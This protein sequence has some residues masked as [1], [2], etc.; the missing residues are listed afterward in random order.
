MKL[1]KFMYALMAGM[2]L[3]ACSPGGDGPEPSPTP[4]PSPSPS[5]GDKVDISNQVNGRW[6][7]TKVDDKEVATNNREVI[8]FLTGGIGTLSSWY[9]GQLQVNYSLDGYGLYF[10]TTLANGDFMEYF[11]EVTYVTESEM[12]QRHY[13]YG[14]NK[15]YKD[16]S[17]YRVYQKST[18][19]IGNKIIG[20]W[21]DT[22][23]NAKYRWEFLAN[24]TYNQYQKN[25]KGKWQ[26][27]D[28]KNN[29]YFV[30]SNWLAIGEENCWDIVQVTDTHMIWSALRVDS[31]G[32]TYEEAISLDKTEPE[33]D[34][35]DTTGGIDDMPIEN[36]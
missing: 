19:T 34:E 15:N 24:G 21:E 8:S 2:V 27:V 26:K 30:D 14:E 13:R 9:A 10:S 28:L 4:S 25:A 35:T 33:P 31:T 5:P 20:L 12:E 22:D 17:G 11:T 7:L 1:R 6:V 36:L 29:T 32:K 18:V 3:A 23:A 16:I